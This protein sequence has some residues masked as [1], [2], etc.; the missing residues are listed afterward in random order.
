MLN[1]LP[2]TLYRYIGRTF[3]GYVAL[4]LGMLLGVVLL[5]D[6]LELFRRASKKAELDIFAVL[7]MSLLKLPEVGQQIIPLAILFLLVSSSRS[8]A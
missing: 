1:K 7:Q 2:L 5:F 8:I 3:A 4:M 6:T